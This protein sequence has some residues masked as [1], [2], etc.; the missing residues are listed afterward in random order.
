MAEI[1]LDG[2][3]PGESLTSGIKQLPYDRPPQYVDNKE[4]QERLWQTL[5]RPDML[6]RV[7]ALFEIGT[8]VDE[9]AAQVAHGMFRE[10]K[11]AAQNAVMVLPSLTVMLY[12]IGEAFGTKMRIS[13]KDK[14]SGISQ[15]EI[16]AAIKRSQGKGSSVSERTDMNNKTM[17]GFK[18]VM[19]SQ[20]NLTKNADNVGFLSAAKEKM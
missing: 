3:I 14:H 16:R 1:P 20:E 10:G 19:G 13:T 17:R 9:L 6:R 12:R 15:A 7:N 4:I 8:P 18:A 11:I 2:A 5:S